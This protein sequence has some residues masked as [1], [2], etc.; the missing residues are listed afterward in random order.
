MIAQSIHDAGQQFACSRKKDSGISSALIGI[1]LVQCHML[2]S[3][4]HFVYMFLFLFLQLS[5]YCSSG[6]GFS[7][8]S[9]PCYAKS[10][11]DQGPFSSYLM[12]VL[13]KRLTLNKT[14]TGRLYSD[15]CVWKKNDN[16][17]APPLHTFLRYLVI[18]VCIHMYVSDVRMQL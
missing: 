10:I 2:Y 7:I 3:L 11:S 17:C 12:F 9:V 15:F 14:K 16:S 8:F 5:Q 1:A 6:H 18:Y 13:I 4:T